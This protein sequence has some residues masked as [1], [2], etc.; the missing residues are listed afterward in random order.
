VSR[1]GIDAIQALDVLRFCL[2][3]RGRTE[4]TF[5]NFTLSSGHSSAKVRPRPPVSA[6]CYALRRLSAE[7]DEQSAAQDAAADDDGQDDSGPA[8]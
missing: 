7:L 1:V 3:N 4:S 8:G 2:Q 6:Q 5:E